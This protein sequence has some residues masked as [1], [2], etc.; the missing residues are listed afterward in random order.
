MQR[1]R[2][3]LLRLVLVLG[4]A[5]AAVSCSKDDI[6]TTPSSPF[7]FTDVAVSKFVV[8]PATDVLHPNQTYVARFSVNYT[9]SPADDA[10]RG[11]LAVFATIDSHDANGNFIAIVGNLAFTPPPLTA[12]GGIV[13]DSIT[14]TV[15][16]TG[17]SFI[18]V[19]A[20]VGTIANNTYTNSRIGPYWSVK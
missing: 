15:P 18:S 11:T 16:G 5:L 14:F 6:P 13:A 7:L 1:A 3:R 9:L 4:A 19:E 8:P 2:S 12:P 20:G 17:A 10:Q